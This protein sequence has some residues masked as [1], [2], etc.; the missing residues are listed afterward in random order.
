LVVVAVQHFLVRRHACERVFKRCGSDSGATRL[1][2]EFGHETWKAIRRRRESLC[3]HNRGNGTGKQETAGWHDALPATPPRAGAIGF[4]ESAAALNNALRA[5]LLII[6]AE[7]A[8]AEQASAEQAGAEQAGAEQASA[9]SGICREVV[10]WGR[11]QIDSPGIRPEPSGEEGS[12]DEIWFLHHVG[13][14]RDRVLQ[15]H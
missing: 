4:G 6:N 7:A 11:R 15:P 10:E 5:G 1:G 3:G 2:L 14:R 9:I 13:H 12:N 8:G